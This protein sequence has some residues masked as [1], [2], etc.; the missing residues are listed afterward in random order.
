TL[1]WAEMCKEAHSKEDQ[2]LFAIVQGAQFEEL[3][4]RCAERLV[5]LNFDGYAIGGVSVG[6]DKSLRRKVVGFTTPMLPEEKPRYLMG[7]GF[8]SDL[9]HAVGQGIDLFD[10]VAPSRMGRNATAFT[11]EGRLRLRNSAFQDD[12]RPIEEACDCLTCRLYSRAYLSHLFRAQE[13]LG[14]IL[15]TIHNIQFYHRMMLAAREA[16]NANSFASF[17]SEFLSRYAD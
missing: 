13:M 15:L 16:I 6:E 2:A 14:P 4:G 11:E 9:L 10:C 5:E 1:K 3:R 12:R 8:P 7:V 17:C